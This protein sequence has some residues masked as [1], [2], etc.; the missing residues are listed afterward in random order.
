MTR[1]KFPSVADG[2]WDKLMCWFPQMIAQGHGNVMWEE[3]AEKF[4]IGAWPG[5]PNRPVLW[6]R[7]GTVHP[8]SSVDRAPASGAGCT[9]SNP[10]G[11]I[12]PGLTCT[13]VGPFLCRH[14]VPA[15]WPGQACV[16]IA[17]SFCRNSRRMPKDVRE[18]SYLSNLVR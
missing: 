5:L 1:R 11:G 3:T 6:Y 2:R 17:Q 12:A 15:V 9:G 13:Q 18:I 8:R 14:F 7:L 10:V 16:S 4:R